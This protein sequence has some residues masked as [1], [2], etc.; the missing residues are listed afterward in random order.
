MESAP[1]KKA[2]GGPSRLPPKQKLPGHPAG[3]AVMRRAQGAVGFFE[4]GADR[5]VLRAVAFT[6]AAADALGRE[7]RFLAQADDLPILPP[8][9]AL[10]LGKHLVVDRKSVV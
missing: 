6:L 4:Q 5:Q 2:V 8:A 1:A 9:G 3:H 10:V 7:G